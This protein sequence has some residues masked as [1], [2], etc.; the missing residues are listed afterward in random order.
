MKHL[1][2]L[3]TIDL[4]G[5]DGQAIGSL[6]SQPRRLALLV[7][8]AVES[9]D[10]EVQRDRLLGVFW[11]ELS[12]DHARQSL[13]TA[14]HFLRRSLGG[15]AVVGHGGSLV[16]NPEAVTS[17]VAEFQAALERGESEAALRL[18]GGE[19]LPGFY[20]DEAPPEFERW[21][22]STRST[23]RRSAAEAAW[24][25]SSTEAG[26]GNAPAAGAWARRAAQLCEGDEAA[27]RRSMERLC[28]VG[29]RSGALELYEGLARRLREE[30]GS[31]PSP[32]TEAVIEGIRDA[33]PTPPPG[34]V[35][36]REEQGAAG[37]G[38]GPARGS[39]GRR[40]W[41][42][43]VMAGA[44]LAAIVA[45]VL[46]ARDAPGPD[47]AAADRA[48]RSPTIHVDELRDFSPGDAAPDLAGA[49]TMELMG[50]LSESETLRV[51]SLARAGGVATATAQPSFVVRGGVIRSDSLVRVTTILTDGASG[52]TLDR[53]MAEAAPGPAA[54]LTEQLGEDLARQ[55]RRRVGRAI[56]D[57]ARGATS[58]NERALALVRAAIRDIEASDSL[59]RAGA[60]EV[61]VMALAAADSQLALA[62]TL[63][64][65]WSEPFV[66]RAEAAYREMWLYLYPP[67]R[68]PA[69]V[70]SA[71]QTGLRNAD[72]ALRIAAHD[73][74]A[75]E[76]RGLLS[77]WQWLTRSSGS[78]TELEEARRRAEADL[79]LATDLDPSR[80][81]AW[82]A[83]SAILESRGD[84]AAANLAARRALRADPYLENVVEIA[85]RLFT[86]SLEVGDARA[87]AHWCEELH[88]RQPGSWLADYCVLAPVAWNGPPPG[89]GVD[90]IRRMWDRA[91]AHR[92]GVGPA[93]ARLS[94][95][96][97][98]ALAKAGS[99]DQLREV[100]ASTDPAEPDP[101]VW[102]LNAWGHLVLDEE[103]L[104]VLAL[105]RLAALSL[106]AAP[107]YIQSRRFTALRDEPRIR[108][109]RE[110][111]MERTVTSPVGSR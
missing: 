25:L 48:D 84:F 8:L 28:E 93:G 50:R 54:A 79:R 39:R 31:T 90:S 12:Q 80:G 68:D 73:A 43:P 77:H 26:A 60:L 75:L 1:T 46:M 42:G 98:I 7:Y 22:E 107:H 104:A 94:R 109:I 57:H 11:P 13:R 4:R 59:R 56:E 29:D 47:A 23:L 18:Y 74:A 34:E 106:R 30:Y 103:E 85:V 111:A 110:D 38:P 69:R 21:L 65:G 97:A 49:L 101:E 17:D 92:S 51:I 66:Q 82:A 81:R 95:L 100:L 53:V 45:G 99:V 24:T 88:R 96:G 9:R 62:E 102:A 14:L 41:R 40:S 86:T 37:A 20:L 5:E 35:D 61:S 105:E 52:A 72:A 44:V 6:L 70:A 63:A 15:D 10:G 2:V 3:G 19:L 32:E 76:L 89:A 83:L 64:P 78:E 71:I 55:I 36:E 67:Q 33:D 16:L 87:A 108:A 58:K 27:V 91:M